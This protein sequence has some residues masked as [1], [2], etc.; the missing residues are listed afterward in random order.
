LTQ[1]NRYGNP[2]LG[3]LNLQPPAGGAP[4]LGFRRPASQAARKGYINQKN[5]IHD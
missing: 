2:R 1:L 3:R 5:N 4:Q